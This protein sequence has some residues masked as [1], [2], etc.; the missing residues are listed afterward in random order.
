MAFLQVVVRDACAEMVDLVV[1][2]VAGEPLQD[3]RQLVKR[4]A[5]QRCR[6][7]IPVFVARPV[8]VLELMLHVEQPDAGTGTDRGSGSEEHTSALQSLMRISSD[9]FC[10]K[11][12]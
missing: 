1:A 9:V 4:A 11:K 5:L 12:K 3:L 2:D 6:R 7:V 8:H 10:L